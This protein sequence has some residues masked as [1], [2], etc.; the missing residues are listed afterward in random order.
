MIL[1]TS[2]T[3]G[4]PKGAVHSHRTL[5]MGIHLMIGKLTT[6]MEPSWELIKQALRTL[7]T[8]RRLPWLLEIML[9]TRDIK[10]IKLLLLTPMY[11]IAGYFQ[12]LLVLLTGGRIIIMERFHPQ[13]ALELVQKEKVTLIFGVPPQFRAMVARPDFDSYDVS[14]IVLSVTGAMVVPPQVVKDMKEKI[15]GFVMIVYGAT[16]MIGGS[17]TWATDP[18]D[19][20][21]ESVGRMDS[22][23][24]LE[25]KVVDENREVLQHGEVGEIAVRSP[26]LMEGY[27]KRPE[28]TADALDEN[29]W[30]Y[31]GDMGMIDEQG[32]V[33][34][35]GRRGD[36]IIRAGANIYPAEIENHL[37]THPEINQVAVVGI[38]GE[39]GEK[40]CAYVV[41]EKGA[42][43]E[44]GDII[45]YC[46]GKI[47]AY[48]V[49]EEVVFVEELPVTPALHK[50]KHYKLKQ[51]SIQERNRS[52]S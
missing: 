48:K 5:L 31:S 38:P 35:L 30:Y 14:S 15:G 45:Q 16:E 3:T 42:I 19:K 17:I 37:L 32:Y 9:A 22:M 50:V 36:L 7:K 52:S 8:I 49:P 39:G 33:H 28:A 21:A 29:G 41:P 44:A 47:A 2:G 18:E 23:R 11:H 6:A 24:E 10:Q 40:V 43:L 1:Y 20:Q 25:F 51:Q 27:Y 12:I 4:A 46:W 26:T 13:K 34:V